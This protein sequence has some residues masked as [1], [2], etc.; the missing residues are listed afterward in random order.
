MFAR[1]P[2]PRIRWA[3]IFSI[4][5]LCDQFK[6]YKWIEEK[7]KEKRRGEIN[8]LFS[9]YF[10][11]N[12]MGKW[13]P[14]SFASYTRT[15]IS[16]WE[17]TQQMPLWTWWMNQPM[18]TSL[19][20][21]NSFVSFICISKRIDLYLFLCFYFLFFPCFFYFSKAISA[22]EVLEPYLSRKENARMTNDLVQNL[23]AL[24]REINLKK[25]RDS[26]EEDAWGRTLRCISALGMLSLI[27]LAFFL[28]FYIFFKL[29]FLFWFSLC[30]RYPLIFVKR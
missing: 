22:L 3:A 23:M 28:L 1:D 10:T 8:C 24:L 4:A 29:F 27:F 17:S 6:V 21:P 30:L 5:L 14:F 9:I 19:T 16:E 20:T 25:D 18:S 2:H 7:D 11:L 12:F 13:Y 26:Y 15:Q